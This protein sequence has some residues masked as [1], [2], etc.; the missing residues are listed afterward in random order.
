[1]F[2]A[3]PDFAACKLL[4]ETLN[5]KHNNYVGWGRVQDRTE[6][7]KENFV[8]LEL[9]LWKVLIL[10]CCSL[11]PRVVDNNKM[12]SVRYITSWRNTEA[13]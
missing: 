8:C 2:L 6:T 10:S 11:R 1:M 3:R 4:F 9:F 7:I 5:L 12:L 13:H